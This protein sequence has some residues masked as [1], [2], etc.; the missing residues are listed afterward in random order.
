MHI[1]IQMHIHIHV[2]IHIH[3]H[4]HINMHIHIHVHIHVH[5]HIHIHIHIYTPSLINLHKHSEQIEKTEMG[6]GEHLR[7]TKP[8]VSKNSEAIRFIILK[9]TD[10]NARF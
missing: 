7:K 4:I 5:I 8:S 9:D 3:M 6:E 2:H 1:H 10:A